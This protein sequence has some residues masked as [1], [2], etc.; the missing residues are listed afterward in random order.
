MYH[1]SCHIQKI[2]P[3]YDIMEKFKIKKLS[4]VT[5]NHHTLFPTIKDLKQENVKISN[6]WL[7]ILGVTAKVGARG[8][9]SQ[10]LLSTK[11][12]RQHSTKLQYI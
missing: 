10:L 5:N 1:I 3:S 4:Y 11:V 8:P 12:L 6:L 7:D 2:R 9:D